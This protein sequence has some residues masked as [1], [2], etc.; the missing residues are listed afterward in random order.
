MIP[1]ISV[2]FSPLGKFTW[3]LYNEEDVDSEHL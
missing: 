2:I 3:A 1:D